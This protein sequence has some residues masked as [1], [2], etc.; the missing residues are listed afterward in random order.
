MVSSVAEGKPPVSSLFH[1]LWKAGFEEARTYPCDPVD[2]GA[3]GGFPPTRVSTPVVVKDFYKS[4]WSLCRKHTKS[5]STYTYSHIPSHTQV[6]TL[7]HTPGHTFLYT[8]VCRYTHTPTHTPS[9]SDIHVHTIKYTLTHNQRLHS[10]VHV[11]TTHTHVHSHV[12]TLT[13][14]R[15]RRGT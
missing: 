12:L 9:H 5:R 15:T 2:P 7:A 3:P 10:Y 13:H 6:V 8:N 4:S 11:T 1:R 14:I